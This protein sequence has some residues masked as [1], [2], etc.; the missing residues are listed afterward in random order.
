MLATILESF[1]DGLRSRG[2]ISCAAILAGLCVVA[3]GFPSG[4]MAQLG[5]FVPTGS[6]SV[7][8][9]ANSATGT[10]LPNGKVLVA[11]GTDGSGSPLSSAELYDP[12]T[13]QFTLTGNM[14]A[15]R[16]GHTATLLK[17][18]KVL[19]AGGEGPQTTSTPTCLC[20]LVGPGT[21][22]ELYD[23][24]TETFTATG[25]MASAMIGHT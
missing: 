24:T 7:S 4:A 22:A 23:P 9:A 15:A 11:G 12:A 8:R 6:M 19:I 1:R 13:G 25:V 16:A 18:G 21:A 5:T 14:T 10:L 17:T 3:G 20:L 2:L